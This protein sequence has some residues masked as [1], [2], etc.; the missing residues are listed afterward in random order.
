MKNNQYFNQSNIASKIMKM[1]CVSFSINLLMGIPAANAVSIFTPD[2]INDPSSSSMPNQSHIGTEY[3]L[4]KNG[5][6]DSNSCS[7]IQIG[8]QE[9]NENYGSENVGL[10]P[11]QYYKPA[12]S[13]KLN[14]TIKIKEKIVVGVSPD[15]PSDEDQMLTITK[16]AINNLKTLSNQEMQQ[17]ENKLKAVNVEM[18]KQYVGST[19][20]G[21]SS[22]LSQYVKYDS[23]SKEQITLGSNNTTTKITNLTNGNVTES[24]TDVINGSQLYNSLNNIKE[25][26]GGNSKLLT[27]NGETKIS[28]SDIGNTGKNT[29]HD[30][31]AYINGRITSGSNYEFKVTTDSNNPQTISN[32]NTLQFNSGNNIQLTQNGSNITIGTKEN[33]NVKNIS[34]SEKVKVGNNGVELSNDGLDLKGGTIENLQTVQD[35]Y[36]VQNN[37]KAVNVETLR[38]SLANMPRNN[39]NVANELNHLNNKMQSYNKES[40]AGVAGAIAMSSLPRTYREGTSMISI[41]VGHFKGESSAAI[42]YGALSDN[43]KHAIQ[44]NTSINTQN[45]FGIGLGYGYIW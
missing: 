4:F 23:P 30:A 25:I 12:V 35:I 36:D 31:I 34:A 41:G 45:D 44:L 42:G 8:M 22:D 16:D 38:N 1:L 9:Y 24:S 39:V 15:N 20:T 18:L 13:F 32:G 19:N 29:I 11:I 10:E 7:N 3:I 40:R 33:I 14:D 17:E 26:V 21:S 27:A 37:N 6:V 5:D 2:E 28:V 43:G